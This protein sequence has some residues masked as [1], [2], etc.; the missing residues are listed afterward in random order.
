LAAVVLVFLFLAPD[1]VRHLSPAA[2]LRVPADLIVATALILVLPPKGRR[3][4]VAVVGGLLGVLAILKILSLGFST[5]LDRA[6]DPVSDWSFLGS[7]ATYLRLSSGRTAEVLAIIGAILLGAGI[8]VAAVFG[9]RGITRV[10]IAHRRPTS[11]VLGGLAVGWVILA[12][13]GAQVVTAVPVAAHDGYDRAYQV[14]SGIQAQREF[15]AAIKTDPFGDVP[16]DRLLT[17]LRG[18]DVVIAIVESYGRIALQRPEISS[19]VDPILADGTARL[20]RAGYAARSGFLTS[21][22]VGGGSWLA[23]STML[24]G[25]WVDNQQRFRT[26]TTSDR[27]TL[28]SAFVK[29]GGRAVAVMPATV[30]DFPEAK[31]FGYNQ[32]YA[33][34]DLAYKGPL[35]A[36]AMMPDQYTLSQFQRS[37]RDPANRAPVMAVIPLISSHA[38]WE[39][40]PTLRDWD[41]V[42]DGSTFE[43]KP[44]SG[45]SAD[46]V[47][48]RDPARLRA[49]YG[50]AIAYT[51][52]TLL[53][54][55]ET[56]GDDDLVLVFFGDH[57]PAPAV[58]GPDAGHDVPITIVAR[59]QKVIDRTASWGWTPGLRP[60]DD[61]PVWRMDQF[62]DRFLTAFS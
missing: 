3:V 47:I 7:G 26:L 31:F 40:V 56:Y 46:I 53:S 58:T 34:K 2:F 44:G 23:D 16:P 24:S 27:L 4:A 37:E 52:D 51:L 62:R 13:T 48:H 32:V 29:S 54:Y 18:K 35:Y 60:A 19:Q 42:G 25:L 45:D 14:A 22:T 8:V 41:K 39:P 1:D 33:S 50:T 11:F 10:A 61:A 9:F 15:A 57:Q 49:D 21:P 5:V 12:L 28:T 43:A 20:A 6:F 30:A 59:D 36:F 17:G 38:P 55:V